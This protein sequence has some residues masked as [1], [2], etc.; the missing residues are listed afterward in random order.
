[1]RELCDFGRV[2]F[3]ER[4]FAASAADVGAATVR[5]W[6]WHDRM[7]AFMAPY[8]LLHLAHRQTTMERYWNEYLDRSAAESQET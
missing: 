8:D 6:A 3:V 5:R 4:G 7:Q 2:E 1:M